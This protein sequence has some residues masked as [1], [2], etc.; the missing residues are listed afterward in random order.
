MSVLE[1][2]GA[3]HELIA[4]IQSPTD[5]QRLLVIVREF[6]AA[7]GTSPEAITDDYEDGLSETEVD[8][9]RRAIERSDDP[10][11]LISNVEAKKILA[12]WLSRNQ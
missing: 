8:V 4:Q 7:F 12:Q 11:N 3:I 10:A 1:T 2:K 6:M 9:F 5:A